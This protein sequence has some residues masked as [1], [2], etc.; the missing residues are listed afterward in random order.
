M[1]PGSA[2]RQHLL[3]SRKAHKIGGP[4]RSEQRVRRLAVHQGDGDGYRDRV[5]ELS[6]FGHEGHESG[7]AG[8]SDADPDP[9]TGDH[10]RHHG[11]KGGGCTGDPQIAVRIPQKAHPVEEGDFSDGP[12]EQHRPRR[13]GAEYQSRHHPRG[14]ALVCRRPPVFRRAA[15]WAA[16]VGPAAASAAAAA[17]ASGNRRKLG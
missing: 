17:A 6:P 5:E 16:S 3:Q 13:A 14:G 11:E 7:A 10:G 2:R 9:G 12:P 4:S 1:N 8:Q 15:Q